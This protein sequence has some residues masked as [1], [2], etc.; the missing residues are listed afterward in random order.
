MKPCLGVPSTCPPTSRMSDCMS[1]RFRRQVVVAGAIVIGIGLIVSG[2]HPAAAQVTDSS[3]RFSTGIVSGTVTDSVNRSVLADALVQLISTD[4]AISPLTAS[5]D[6]LGHYTIEGIRPGRYRL[7]FVHPF[8]DSLGIELALKDIEVEQGKRLFVNLSVPSPHGLHTTICG[9]QSD[10]AALIV[11]FV[12]GAGD[13]E[14]LAR[15]TVTAEWLDFTVTSNHVVKTISR[16]VA[17]SSDNGWFALCNIP[18]SGEVALVA[19]R[20]GDSTGLVEFKVPTNRLLWVA[21]LI[22]H[23]R[24]SLGENESPPARRAPAS[25]GTSGWGG[26]SGSVLGAANGRPIVGAHVRVGDA[27]STRTNEKGEWMILNPPRG[28]QMIEIVA[29]GYYPERRRVDVV[30]NAPPVRTVL[31]TLKA[32]LD[33]VRISAT[34][35]NHGPHDGSFERRRRMSQGH[36]LTPG[37]ILRFPAIVT[38]DLLRNVPGLQVDRESIKMRGTFETWCSPAIFIDG[39]YMSF[40]TPDDINDMAYPHDVAGLE[41]YSEA[42][43]PPQFQ[44]AF[45]GCGSV[46]IWTKRRSG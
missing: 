6:S 42:T 28:T 23:Y 21:L 8:L 33:T 10:S 2:D 1:S 39:Q 15:A 24:S 44:I 9:S 26:L 5:S 30:S 25:S 35:L 43:V 36:F 3:A 12:R 18:A 19:T 16:R 40:L 7:G 38:S 22:G 11:G 37:D 17:T 46:V 14:P 41:I 31:S 27:S 34:R 32:V 45:H 4:K 20:G 29:L 13:D